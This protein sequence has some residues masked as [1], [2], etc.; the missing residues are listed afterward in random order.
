MLLKSVIIFKICFLSL[1]KKWIVYTL[2]HVQTPIPT[3]ILSV[4]AEKRSPLIPLTQWSPTP[5]LW[6][7][8]DRAAEI[9]PVPLHALTLHSLF[10]A[11]RALQH[12]CVSAMQLFVY[13]HQHERTSA[14]L[15]F[16]HAHK[17]ACTCVSA[18][19]PFAHVWESTCLCA[20]ANS[21]IVLTWEQHTC[22][23]VQTCMR[24][25]GVCALLSPADPWSEKGWR[26]LL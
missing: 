13:V 10:A 18:G 19:L 3:P 23:I 22:T 7:E 11:V 17:H 12:A 15:L 8:P 26:P 24:V 21:S 16:V 4:L 5:G 9:S 14:V 25:R 6:P 1:M 20:C 2:S